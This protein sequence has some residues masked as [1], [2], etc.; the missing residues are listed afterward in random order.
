M[1]RFAAAVEQRSGQILAGSVVRAA[2]AAGLV[3]AEADH[4]TEDPGRGVKGVVER[5]NVCV[6]A[7]S[8][9]DECIRSTAPAPANA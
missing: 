8:Y 1:L 5:R 9:S 2:R 7:R 3:V 4:V 6:G